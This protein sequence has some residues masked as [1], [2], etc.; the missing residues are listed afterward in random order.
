MNQDKL[1][2]NDMQTGN[3]SRPLGMTKGKG[4]GKG[5]RSSSPKVEEDVTKPK[6]SRNDGYR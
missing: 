3:V 1:K 6:Q 2:K 4:R 5:S